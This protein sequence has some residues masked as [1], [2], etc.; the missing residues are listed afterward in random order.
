MT[1][2]RSGA[3]SLPTYKAQCNGQS[4]SM[5]PHTPR[6]AVAGEAK[7]AG[8]CVCVCGG[9]AVWSLES[10][11]KGSRE[12]LRGGGDDLRSRK[13]FHSHNERLERT[14]RRLGSQD[15]AGMIHLLGKET[16]GKI[17]GEP[18]K[19]GVCT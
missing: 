17:V 15:R 1:V 14:V 13:G 6:D 3:L 2:D 4:T 9:L 12:G 7:F 16:G 19:K 18:K 11:S 10:P 5:G 8:V